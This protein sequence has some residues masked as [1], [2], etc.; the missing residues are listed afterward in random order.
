MS[1][2]QR[3]QTTFHV[4]CTTLNISIYLHRCNLKMQFTYYF[5]RCS[6]DVYKCLVFFKNYYLSEFSTIVSSTIV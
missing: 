6:I 1:T 5:R 2:E 4:N 3:N